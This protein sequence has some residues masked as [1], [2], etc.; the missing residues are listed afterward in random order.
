MK[1]DIEIMDLVWT[2]VKSS[3]LAENINGKCYKGRRPGESNTEDL[4]IS[5]LA[6]QNGEFQEAYINVNIYVPDLRRRTAYESDDARLREL[7]RLS[8][9]VLDLRFG[10]GW[11]WKMDSQRVYAVDGRNEQMINNRLFFQNYNE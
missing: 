3:P 2:Y 8:D 4:C 11:R 6:N 5:V 7:C 10:D 1:T 9:D